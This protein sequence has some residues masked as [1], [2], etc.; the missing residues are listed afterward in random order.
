MTAAETAFGTTWPTAAEAPFPRVVC[1]LDGSG[2]PFYP[3]VS[4]VPGDDVQWRSVPTLPADGNGLRWATEDDLVDREYTVLDE[5]ALTELLYNAP[6][7]R[8]THSRTE[9]G[10]AV[11]GR[12]Y[13]CR[14]RV[15]KRPDHNA[16]HRLAECRVWARELTGATS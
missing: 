16:P 11:E 6:L 8:G 15:E 10:Q 2:W 4:S 3:Y 9:L 1:D 12:L 7:S 5:D 14:C 13:A